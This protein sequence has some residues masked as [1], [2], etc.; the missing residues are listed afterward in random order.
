MCGL[1]VIRRIPFEKRPIHFQMKHETDPTIEHQP[2]VTV[3]IWCTGVAH[4]IPSFF[5]A[6][7]TNVYM[8]L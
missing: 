7:Q 8:C 3:L 1:Q 4:C 6:Y 5:A 2:Y